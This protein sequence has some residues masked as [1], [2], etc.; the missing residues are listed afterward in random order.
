MNG[1]IIN[2]SETAK[3]LGVIFDH[4]LHWKE[5]CTRSHQTNNEDNNALRNLYPEQM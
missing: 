3:F 4:E 5:S 2:P 1:N